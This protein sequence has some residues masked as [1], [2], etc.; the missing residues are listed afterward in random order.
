M[1]LRAALVA[2]LLA[3]L[4]AG[5]SGENGEDSASSTLLAPSSFQEVVVAELRGAGLEAEPGAEL[6]VR[7]IRGPNWVQLDLTEAFES[8]E[9]DPGRRDELVAGVVEVAE[10]RLDA[11]VGDTALDDVRSDVMPLLKAPFE[12]RTYGFEPAATPFPGDLAIIYA[13]DTPEAFTIV[14][15]QDV[16]HWGTSIEQIHELA[17]GNLRRQTNEEQPLL[18]EPSEG[19]ELC[20]WASGDGYDATRMIV[21]GLRRQI[22]KEYGGPAAYA[23]P[24]EN[25]FVALPLELLRRGKTEEAFRTKVERDFQ[26]SEDPLSPLIFVERDGELVVKR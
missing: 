2:C 14:Q 13:V 9:Q 1:L 10:Q 21:P 18:C 8:Y 15:P 5:C 19:Q 25:V 17:V 12:L 11:G 22:V 3:A 16:E 4:L 23:V 26:T 24:M 6:E 20:G 7:A